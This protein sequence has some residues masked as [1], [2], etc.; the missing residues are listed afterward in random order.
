MCTARTRALMTKGGWKDSHILVHVHQAYGLAE[1][2][3]L[4]WFVLLKAAHTHARVRAPVA[5][6]RALTTTVRLRRV[7]LC[8][9]SLAAGATG[10]WCGLAREGAA[11]GHANSLTTVRLRGSS[12]RRACHSAE[13]R[14]A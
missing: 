4:E 11:T 8:L 9:H 5:G 14:A 12:G 6:S 10:I 13:G 1:A 7:P 2:S 3:V